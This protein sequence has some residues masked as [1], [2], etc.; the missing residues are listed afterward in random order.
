M[1]KVSVIIPVY[2]VEPY[3]EKCLDSL[4]NQTLKDIEIICINDCSTDNSLNILEQFKNKDERIKLINLKENKGAAIARNEGL[5]IA[6]G[7]YLGFVDPDDYVDLN[8]YEEL[9]KKAKQDDADIVKAK[10][11]IINF[12]KTEIVSTLNDLIKKENNKFKFDY[13][14]TTAIYKNTLIFDNDIKLPEECLTNEDVVFLFKCVLN[15]N[16]LSL[17]DNVFYYYI[18]RE[19]SLNKIKLDFS[20]AV[21]ALYSVK[22]IIN[23]LNKSKLFYENCDLYIEVYISILFT[24]LNIV[25]RV[26]ELEAKFECAKCLIELYNS[27]KDLKKLDEMYE[28]VIIKDYIKQNNPKGMVNEFLKYNSKTKLL[29]SNILYKLRKNVKKDVT[30][31]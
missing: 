29:G 19:N 9:Y 3:L 4:I 30:N 17:I 5:K 28:L 6:K 13:E 22:L 26:D 7:E 2:N 1:S 16:K 21:S 20:F 14:W 15:S 25:Y 11:K 8:F 23:E 27:C 18:R 10:R 12:D 24:I 31:V